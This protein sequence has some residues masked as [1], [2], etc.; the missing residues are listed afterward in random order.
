MDVSHELT[1]RRVL[2]PAAGSLFTVTFEPSIAVGSGPLFHHGREVRL[3]RRPSGRGRVD[4]LFPR[5]VMRGKTG[6]HDERHCLG[7]FPDR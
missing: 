5:H 7:C 1:D 2:G 6:A 4:S 3:D